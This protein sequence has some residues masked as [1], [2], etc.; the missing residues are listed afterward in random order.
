MA[1][2]AP[3]EVNKRQVVGTTANDLLDDTTCREYYLIIARASGEA[4]NVVSF[5]TMCYSFRDINS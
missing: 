5:S 4:D 1:A 2:A 3:L